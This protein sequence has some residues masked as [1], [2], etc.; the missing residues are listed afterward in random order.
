MR[1]EWKGIQAQVAMRQN[2]AFRKAALRPALI[3]DPSSAAA[4][5]I[6]YFGIQLGIFIGKHIA[7]LAL[8]RGRRGGRSFG[9]CRGRR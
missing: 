4:A 1:T 3:R 6:L 2:L 9:G 8:L 7:K 5:D